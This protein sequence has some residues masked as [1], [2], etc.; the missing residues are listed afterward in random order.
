MRPKVKHFPLSQSQS[1]ELNPSIWWDDSVWVT[2]SGI[3]CLNCHQY[4]RLQA[5]L[6]CNI[7]I[8][9]KGITSCLKFWRIYLKLHGFLA[10]YWCGIFGRYEMNAIKIIWY[11]HF[12]K[13]MQFGQDNQLLLCDHMITRITI[14]YSLKEGEQ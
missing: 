13:S 5:Q 9:G 14:L 3:L 12:I 6:G 7:P 8:V 10:E 1:A 11:I 2:F 4:T